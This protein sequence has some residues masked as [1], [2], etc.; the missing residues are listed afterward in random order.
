[1]VHVEARGA[2]VVEAAGRH[3]IYVSQPKRGRYNHRKGRRRGENRC[4]LGVVSD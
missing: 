1:M 2:L 3:A 4:D